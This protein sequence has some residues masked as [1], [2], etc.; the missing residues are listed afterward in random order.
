MGVRR[1]SHFSS[2]LG[3]PPAPDNRLTAAI[4]T[5][6]FPVSSPLTFRPFPPQA[7][8]L[9]RR[10]YTF[11]IMGIN[12][13]MIFITTGPTVTTNSEGSTQKKMGKMSFTPNFAAF[14]SAICRA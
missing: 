4:P 13:R 1:S 5:L 6:N 14:S 11:C 7:L 3:T 2:A 12:S 8:D 10:P 9:V